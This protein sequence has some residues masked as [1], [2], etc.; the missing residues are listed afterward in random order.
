MGLENAVPGFADGTQMWKEETGGL[1]KVCSLPPPPPPPPSPLQ[2]SPR[3][4]SARLA[5]VSGNAHIVAVPFT[6]WQK[7][8]TEVSVL[9]LLLSVT[10]NY[11]CPLQLL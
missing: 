9:C 3:F 7:C 6:S 4:S 10:T 1:L 8:M 2:R 5:S 11:S